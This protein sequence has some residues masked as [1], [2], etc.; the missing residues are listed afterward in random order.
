VRSGA[1]D[2][3]SNRVLGFDSLPTTIQAAADKVIGQADLVNTAPNDDDQD[4]MSHATPS[5]RTLAQ[6]RGLG[7]LGTNLYVTD[8][9]HRILIIAGP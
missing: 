3:G 6:P 7:A 2:Y 9:N 1:S 4:G 5:G 8:G